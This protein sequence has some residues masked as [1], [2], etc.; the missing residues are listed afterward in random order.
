MA[1]RRMFAKGV[2][3]SDAFLD[4]PLSAQALYFHLAM[5]ADDD[6]FV[7]APRRLMRMV[8]AAE[9]DLQR[10]EG[11]YLY[12]FESGAC[13]VRHWKVHNRIR[14]DRYR[15]TMFQ[16]E[17]AQVE[18]DDSCVYTICQPSGIPSDNQMATNCQPSGIPSGNQVTTNCPSTG[19]PRLG[20]VS[21]GKVS[22][23]ECSSGKEREREES[24]DEYSSG[25]ESGG[26]ES[27]DQFSPGEWR[28]DEERRDEGR[29]APGAAAPSPSGKTPP[30]ERHGEYGWI[31]LT[32]EQYERLLA[33]LGR[34]EL[35]RCITYLDES[36]Q[37]SGNKNR[38]KDWNLLIRRCHREGWG[39]RGGA[40]PGAAPPPPAGEQSYD[41]TGLEDRLLL[42]FM[43]HGV[44]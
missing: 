39:L 43:E 22:S 18:D 13:L 40:R 20:K 9:E 33:E 35:E 5:Q 23:G 24:P 10:L 21:L 30:M 12:F 19:I 1:E 25:Q 16:T 32:G 31:R 26:E 3:S 37:Q 15:E 2:V 27:R 4:L 44:V 6:G 29:R 34:T 42:D 11:S 17:R 7:G 28:P 41:L 14:N 8:G 36:A 38:W